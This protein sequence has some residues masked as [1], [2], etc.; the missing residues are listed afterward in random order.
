MTSLKGLIRCINENGDIARIACLYSLRLLKSPSGNVSETPARYSLSTW[1]TTIEA[2]IARIQKRLKNRVKIVET[3]LQ[4]SEEARNSLLELGTR[5]EN[6]YVLVRWGCPAPTYGD[7][8]IS[9][10][11]ARDFVEKLK[12]MN[13]ELLEADQKVAAA[14]KINAETEDEDAEIAKALEKSLGLVPVW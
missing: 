11:K 14:L 4:H 8:A 7:D 12:P 2:T 6:F 9:E 1:L 3:D 5:L 13:G 10:D